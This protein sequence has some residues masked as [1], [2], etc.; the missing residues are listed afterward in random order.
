[1]SAAAQLKLAAEDK[2]DLEIISAAAQDALVRVSDLAY[3]ARA[4][5]FS[6][7]IDRFRWESERQEPPFER[8]SA[9]LAFDGVLKVRTKRLRR[10][11]PN[12]VASVLSIGF[13]AAEEPPGGVVRIVLAGGGE[14]A[15]D[16]ECIDATLVDLG[17][18]W[19][20]PRRPDHDKG[21]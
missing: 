16:V 15:L 10:E 1:M 19:R 6:L 21:Q 5:R 20:T 9:A 11:A 14:I 3:D 8:I 18:A 12:A 4:R 7:R 13:D 17:A 2:A